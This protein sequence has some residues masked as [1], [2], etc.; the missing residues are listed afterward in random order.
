METTVLITNPLFPDPAAIR[1]A[2]DVIRAG[3]LIA[4]PTET[5]YGLGANALDAGAVGKIFAAKG[6]PATNPV[7]VHIAEPDQALDVASAWPE[8]ARLLAA[9]FW[10]GPLTIVLPKQPMLPDVVTAGGATVGV[11]CPAHPVARALI[12][13]SG[14]PIAAPS[15]NRS[16]ELSPTQPQHVLNSLNGRIDLLLAAGPCSGGIESTVIDLSEQIPRLLRPGLISITEL[17]AIVGTV[18]Y[19]GKNTGPA[20]SPGMMD[21]HYVPRTPL[22][23]VKASLFDEAFHEALGTNERVG[24]IALAQPGSIWETPERAAAQLYATLHDFD[25]ADMDEV[26]ICRPPETPE[27]AGIRDRLERA[28]HGRK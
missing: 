11:R 21:R 4:F 16:T 19:G 27:W 26:I 2:A 17:Q 15:A 23:L 24:T 5:V 18:E 1:R 14:K 8:A 25:D 9:R 7:I 20:H 28:T 3:G 12:R 22:R 6:R 13:A 10:P